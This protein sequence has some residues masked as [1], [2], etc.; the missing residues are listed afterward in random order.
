M[1]NMSKILYLNKQKLIKHIYNKI[2]EE[3]TG[4]LVTIIII[5]RSG[6]G[7]HAGKHIIILNNCIPDYY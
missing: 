2:V 3:K 5:I 7:S 6:L 1:F 4:L